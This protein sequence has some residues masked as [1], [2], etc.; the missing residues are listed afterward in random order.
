M[1]EKD[2]VNDVLSMINSSLVDYATVIAQSADPNLR[3]T[4]QQLRDSDEQ[5]QYQLFKLAEQKGY[6]KP[7]AP[8]DREE[9]QQIKTTFS[10]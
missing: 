7:A 9:I 8:A 2:M 3:Q 10:S 4:I 1:Q 5:F 6:Y